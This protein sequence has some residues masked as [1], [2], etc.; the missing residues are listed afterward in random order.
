MRDLR[1]SMARCRVDDFGETSP[2]IA[3]KKKTL[4]LLSIGVSLI[5]SS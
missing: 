4:I 2:E 5:D 1:V 3:P